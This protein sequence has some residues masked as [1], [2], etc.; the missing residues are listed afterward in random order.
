MSKL[1]INGSDTGT[2]R[3]FRLDLPPEAVERFT[4]QAGTGEWPLKYALGAEALRPGFVDVVDI[5]D[6]G[7]MPLSQYMIEAHGVEAAAIGADRARL[8]ALTGHVVLLPA[9]AFDHVSQELTVAPPLSLVGSYGEIRPQGRGPAI[10]TEAAR[11]QGTGTAP[12]GP[13]RGSS[14]TLKLVLAGVAVVILLALVL[15]VS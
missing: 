2:L 5:R 14:A 1:T 3:V 13:G 15:I 9:Q 12:A 7:A 6:L 11:G 4:T 10:V 8:D